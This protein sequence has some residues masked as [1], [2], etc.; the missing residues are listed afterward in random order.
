MIK[1]IA[2]DID[3]TL[4]EDSAPEVCGEILDMIGSLIQRGKVCVIASGRQY[5]SI[6][7]LF[8]QIAEDIVYI[9]DNGAHI[10]YQGKDLAVT[11]MNPEDAK[12]II[13]EYREYGD[14]CEIVVSTPSGC[15]LESKNQVFIDFIQN[16]YHNEFRVVKDVLHEDITIIKVA[17]YRKGGIR[18]LGEGV[19]IPR[20]ENRVK[21]CLAGEEWVD[22]M[23]KTVDKGHALGFLQQY[24]GIK[25]EE[26]M[27]FGDNNNDIGMFQAAQESYA[28]SNARE[29]VRQ[30]AKHTCAPYWE[31]GVL[32]ILK[33]VE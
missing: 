33:S 2:S 17:I 19:F 22:F 14:T 27:V 6:K 24:F 15:L 7:S 21:V 3:G 26:T 1:L 9:A 11:A 20:W 28:V 13:S 12:Q 16:N 5:A 32:K 29:E 10:F 8:S 18:D 30:W 31:K 4:V 23:D 25:R